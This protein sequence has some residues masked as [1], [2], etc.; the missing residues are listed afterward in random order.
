[1]EHSVC[2][3]LIQETA[4]LIRAKYKHKKA[5]TTQKSPTNW[6]T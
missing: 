5:K 6:P 1:M 3:D 4:G 2:T